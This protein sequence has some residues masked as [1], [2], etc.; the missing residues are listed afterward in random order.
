MIMQEYF[1]F[2]LKEHIHNTP[3]QV[4]R[5]AGLSKNGILENDETMD[6]LWTLYQKSVEEYDCDPWFAY[7]DALK[8]VC[9]IDY[10]PNPK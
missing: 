4:F 7:G 8:T 5:N 6:K 2:D 9:H 10:M 1:L 3:E